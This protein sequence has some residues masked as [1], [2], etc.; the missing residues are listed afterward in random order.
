[1]ASAFILPQRGSDLERLRSDFPTIRADEVYLDSVASSLTPMP[2]VDAMTDYY[3]NHRAN[4]HRGSYDLSL[5]ASELYEKGLEKIATF[6]GADPAEL[7][8]TM[9]ATA[10]INEVALTLQF[11]PGD[12]IVLS[13]LEHTS[14]MV[15]WVNLQQKQG[16]VVRWYNPGRAG[17]FDLDEFS[18]VL[19]ERTKLVSMTWVSNV[20]GSVVPVEQVAALLRSRGIMYMIDACQASPHIKMDVHGIGCDFLAFSGHKMLGPTGI[21]VLYLRRDHAESMIPAILGGGTID[22]DNCFCPSLDECD[23]SYCSFTELPYK[24]QAGT[25]PVAETIGLGA[26]VDYLDAVGM[27]AIAAHDRGLMSRALDGLSAVRGVELFGPGDPERQL[28]ILSFNVP[29]LPPSEV[30]RILNERFKVAVRTGHHCAVNYFRE[31]QPGGLP[32]GNVRSSFYLYN[33]LDEVDRFVAAVEQIAAL[34]K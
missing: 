12:E 4:V 18:K 7:V 25:P 1:M 26:A 2:V 11:K 15:P 32:E 23:L 22:T 6:I 17:I 21:G 33:T 30:G 8:M 13:A 27:D 9:N 24:W 14:N 10:A 16:V 28:A 19:T 20:L 31:V 29:G 34:A 3:V 5:R